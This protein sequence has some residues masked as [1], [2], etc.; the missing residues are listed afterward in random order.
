MIFPGT[1]K[2]SLSGAAVRKLLSDHI[3]TLLGGSVRVT[4]VSKKSSYSDELE[5]EFTTDADP[6]VEKASRAASED[7]V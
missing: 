2:L 6:V 3:A 1:N 7:F 5:I 4:D